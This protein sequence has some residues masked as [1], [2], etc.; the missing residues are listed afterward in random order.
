MLT[1]RVTIYNILV[2]NKCDL[3]Q[4]KLQRGVRIRD[5]VPSFGERK[6][7]LQTATRCESFVLPIFFTSLSISLPL[8]ITKSTA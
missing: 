4:A 2:L 7:D 5:S 3:L 1:I 8:L 6:N